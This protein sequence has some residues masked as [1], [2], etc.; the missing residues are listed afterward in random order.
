MIGRRQPRRIP[1]GMMCRSVTDATFGPAE[2]RQSAG[3]RTLRLAYFALIN[4][5]ASLWSVP[6]A[7]A[8]YFPSGDQPKSQTTPEVKWVNGFAGPP[9]IIQ[10]QRLGV[11]ERMSTAARERPS[12]VQR[13][14][15]A[16]P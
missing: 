7:S 14:P 10:L 4:N 15:C 5:T 11:P 13:R 1:V 2:G 16:L 3:A 9:A 6:R 8:M 12:G